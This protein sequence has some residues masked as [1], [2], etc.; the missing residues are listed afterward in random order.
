[1]VCREETAKLVKSLSLLSINDNYLFSALH[2]TTAIFSISR[3]D[4]EHFLKLVSLHARLN[5]H[6]E[7][8]S[9]KKKKYEKSKAYRKSVSK[10]P[11]DRRPKES[12]L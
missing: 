5:S 4:Y 10:D 6:Y 1:M 3:F 11:K 7:A 2:S 9:C 12:I 8:W